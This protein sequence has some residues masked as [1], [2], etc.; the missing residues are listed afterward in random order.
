MNWGCP[1]PGSEI[2]AVRFSALRTQAASSLE[3]RVDARPASSPG[4]SR[5]PRCRYPRPAGGPTKSASPRGHCNVHLRL[6]QTE[7][8]AQHARGYFIA[9]PRILVRDLTPPAVGIR[10]MTHGWIG[11]AGTL[12]ADWSVSDNF[13]SDGVGQ[14]RIVV[15]GQVRWTG[16]PGAGNHGLDLGARRR[17]GRRAAVQVVAEGDGTDGGSATDTIYVD[18]TAP[19]AT[20]LQG[21]AGRTRGR[22]PVAWRATDAMSGV[23]AS[24]R[25]STP[26]RTAG[27][28]GEW[29]DVGGPGRRR[30]TVG[31]RGAARRRRRP[32]LARRHHGRG[33]QRL[34]HGEPP[35][36]GRRRARP[37][38]PAP[39][40]ADRAGSAASTWTSRRPTRCSPSS[41]SARRRWTSTPP[42]TGASR[43]SGSAA[44]RPRPRRGGG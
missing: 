20:E 44:A 6:A 37:G 27:A 5:T 16:A 39:R 24:R 19:R 29:R 3:V 43:A 36:G 25:R 31:D 35:A 41:A 40:R 9:A 21:S 11:A 10:G 14:Q 17:A 15:A 8:R 26:R 42:P 7:T 38:R 22:G 28:P 13:G 34:G 4:P 33:G 1:V 12:R 30:R 2:A 18:R 32:R 23:V